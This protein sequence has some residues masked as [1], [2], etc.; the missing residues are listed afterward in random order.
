MEAK[1]Q[2]KIIQK[3]GFCFIHPALKID[4]FESKIKNFVCL[5]DGLLKYLTD[6][7]KCIAGILP[8]DVT[9]CSV[10]FL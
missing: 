6:C 8:L 9:V 1:V 4:R 7:Q 10:F 2:A 3:V 5:K